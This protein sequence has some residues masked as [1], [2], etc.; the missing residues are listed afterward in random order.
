MLSI[1]NLFVMDP[2][3]M[4]L[5]R[6]V[7][8]GKQMNLAGNELLEFVLA[9]QALARDEIIR[10]SQEKKE[11]RI[12]EEA[13]KSRQRKKED[14]ARSSEEAA[15]F[16]RHKEEE[17]ERIRRH[18]EEMCH[19][20]READDIR[21]R[22]MLQE[23]WKDAEERRR[24]EEDEGECS[25]SVTGRELWC[26]CFR[27]QE[28]LALE[29]AEEIRQH[30]EYRLQRV[31]E[32]L[33]WE[34]EDVARKAAK[35]EREKAIPYIE[36]SECV[37]I[38]INSERR[39]D[40]DVMVNTCEGSIQVGPS[41]NETSEKEEAGRDLP[42]EE[43]KVMQHEDVEK[44]AEIQYVKVMKTTVVKVRQHVK[45]R[46]TATAEDALQLEMVTPDSEA[47][48]V[49]EDGG[50]AS[51]QEASHH[52]TDDDDEDGSMS[53]ERERNDIGQVRVPS[54]PAPLVW[55]TSK[56]P[57]E[58]PRLSSRQDHS[59]KR[60]SIERDR[61]MDDRR[62]SPLS[63]KSRFSSWARKK[64]DGMNVDE[65]DGSSRLMITLSDSQTLYGPLDRI[66]TGKVG[67]DNEFF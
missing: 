65:N 19:L 39:V 58:R 11:A 25:I 13:E 27:E 9:K 14:E 56:M 36:D 7:D 12:A 41:A 49:T 35:E 6:L 55:R 60:S 62:H 31:Y 16:R 33:Q 17:E 20:R 21:R 5:G 23:V 40:F 52:P 26:K 61:W 1:E 57:E 48:Y 47:S 38:P 37:V 59:R 66:K 18:E 24:E 32:R 28:A 3:I 2:H 30:K 4:D 53:E 34:K 15:W 44:T 63:K 64:A 50:D 22:R 67:D 29:E 43:E 46:K 42:I 54:L 10:I 51:E 8:L 45:G